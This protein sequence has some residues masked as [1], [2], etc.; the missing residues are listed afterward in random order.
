MRLDPLHGA[1]AQSFR[2]SKLQ[3]AA[4]S[5]R[6]VAALGGNALLRRGEAM[7]EANQRVNVRAAVAALMPLVRAGHSLFVTHGNGPQIGMIALQ[8]RN[9]PP[10]GICGL[11]VLGAQS[12]GM[13]GYLIEQE[14]R[15]TLP[16]GRS[17]ATVL[18]QVLVHQG[19][20]R[21]QRFEKPVGPLYNEME[22]NRLRH[23]RGWAFLHVGPAGAALFLR[24]SRAKFSA[25]KR[26]YSWPTTARW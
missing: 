5:M 21:L 10:E 23:E 19:D 2:G 20:E 26:S 24:R 6:I 17:C 13:I 12:Q 7:S 11:D 8:N 4:N 16:P 1:P 9:G 15:N 18:T 22:A 3:P 14:M 25:S